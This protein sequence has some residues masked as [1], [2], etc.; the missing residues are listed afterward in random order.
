MSLWAENSTK[1]SSVEANSKHKGA[2]GLANVSKAP[3]SDKIMRKRK[4]E[5]R[6]SKGGKSDI[7]LPALYG[8]GWVFLCRSVWEKFPDIR[9]I[10]TLTPSLNRFSQ[11]CHVSGEPIWSYMICCYICLLYACMLYTAV[12]Y[13]REYIIY[14]ICFTVARIT[15]T[16]TAV[17]R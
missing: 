10:G 16:E 14:A 6:T 3:Q 17:T 8:T 4:R 5:R 9:C 7:V 12:R 2:K 1:C 13:T 11:R 15:C